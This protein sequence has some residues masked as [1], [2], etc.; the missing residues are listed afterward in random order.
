MLRY[1]DLRLRHRTERKLSLSDKR[2]QSLLNSTD[3]CFCVVDIIFN[4]AQQA[5]DYRFSE[6]NL[7]FKR[8]AGV[9][10]DHSLRMRELLPDN[11]V[12]WHRIFGAVALMFMFFGLAVLTA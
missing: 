4:S 9:S 8:L 5:V 6:S 10:D 1:R 7:A 12:Q 2:Y 11:T 3:E